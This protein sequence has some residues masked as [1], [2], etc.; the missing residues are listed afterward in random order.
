MTAFRPKKIVL[1]IIAAAVLAAAPGASH[2]APLVLANLTA[3][4]AASQISTKYGIYIVLKSAF[5]ASRRVTFTLTDAD[6]AGSRLQA[7][8]EL[9]NAL[10][11]DFSKTFVVRKLP[12]DADVPAPIIDSTN[13]VIFDSTTVPAETAINTVAGVDDANIQIAD[14]IG[15]NV[16]LTAATL[17]AADAATQIATQTHTRWKAYYAITANLA[18]SKP[19]GKVIGTIGGSP[20]YELPHINYT[21]IPTAAE[22]AAQQQADAAAA[23]AKQPQASSQTGET[24][25]DNNT[26]PAPAPAYPDYGYSPYSY[27]GYDY[28]YPYG[29]GGGYP[30]YGPGGGYV[31]NGNGLILG[32][33]GGFGN[34][35]IVF[36][37]NGYQPY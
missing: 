29:Y 16:T 25:P 24:A 8:N 33:G 11:A 34:G 31:D 1:G 15:G 20:I 36:Q 32:T 18:G 19:S 28:G 23:A 14:N 5:P 2:A 13:N 26:N 3:R 27:G 30:G 35:P 22:K 37:G 4:E 17:S 12:A 21:H 7:V 10:G 6:S 9:A